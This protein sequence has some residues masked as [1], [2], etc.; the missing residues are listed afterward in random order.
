MNSPTQSGAGTY[1]VD[2][3]FT[4]FSSAESCVQIRA[5]AERG[6]K[7]TRKKEYKHVSSLTRVQNCTRLCVPERNCL[8]KLNHHS[9]PR[10]QSRLFR[11]CVC[12]LTEEETLNAA[13][14]SVFFC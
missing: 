12:C 8:K 14:F 5:P 10:G 6:E 2:G 7:V 1:V 13:F 11:N 4:F 9:S 3:E